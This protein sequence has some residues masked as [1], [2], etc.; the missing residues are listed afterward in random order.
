MEKRLKLTKVQ[1]K[2]LKDLK[3]ETTMFG[4]GCT[5]KEKTGLALVERGFAEIINEETCRWGDSRH[6]NWCVTA[7]ITQKGRDYLTHR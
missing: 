3:V 2:A 7:K 1:M 4:S 5:Y 6:K